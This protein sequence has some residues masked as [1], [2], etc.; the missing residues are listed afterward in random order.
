MRIGAVVVDLVDVKR[1][2]S[3]RRYGELLRRLTR[4]DCELHLFARRWDEAAA[5]DLIC[6]RVPVRGPGARAPICPR[7]PA[8]GP[9]AL[10]PLVFALSAL[11]VTRRWRSRLDLVHSHT[12]SLGDDVVSPGGGAYLAYL[13]AVGRD[14][15]GR[16]G[17]PAW[18]P[19]DHARAFLARRQLRS[20]LRLE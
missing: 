18:R 4:R 15:W 6:H 17:R 19:R 2:G 16:G 5:R 14:P 13:R 10:A 7:G 1:V 12:Q 11:R 3:E 8:R 9:A 20:D